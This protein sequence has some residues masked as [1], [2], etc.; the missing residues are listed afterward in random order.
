MKECNVNKYTSL[1]YLMKCSQVCWEMLGILGW[2]LNWLFIPGKFYKLRA[3]WPALNTPTPGG[4]YSPPSWMEMQDLQLRATSTSNPD[5]SPNIKVQSC[6][7]T[8]L[9]RAAFRYLRLQC[10]PKMIRGFVKHPSSNVLHIKTCAK[11]SVKFHII[12]SKFCTKGR[13]NTHSKAPGALSQRG[14][15]KYLDQ[16]SWRAISGRGGAQILPWDSNS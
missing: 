10:S 4:M 7:I 3:S 16:N 9:L 8:K 5:W 11:S 14:R 6:E 12:V 15:E 2:L 13:E 1:G